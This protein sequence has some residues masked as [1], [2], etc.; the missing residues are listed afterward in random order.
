TMRNAWGS[1]IDVDGVDVVFNGHDHDYERSKPMHNNAP[2]PTTANA[3]VFVVVGSAGADLYD[4]GSDFWTAFSEKTFSF[5]IVRVRT[6]SLQMTAYRDDGT[7]L[8]SMM[9][10]K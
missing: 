7:M 8:D 2:Q 4:N 6:G 3:T 9:L 10:I 5:A 1:I